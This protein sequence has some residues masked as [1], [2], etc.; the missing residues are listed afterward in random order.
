MSDDAALDALRELAEA[1]FPR[2]YEPD[3]RLLTLT[4]GVG[5]VLPT[6]AVPQ[7]HAARTRFVAALP[8]D[9]QLHILAEVGETGAFANASLGAGWRITA[10]QL[11]AA[12][13]GSA[14]SRV[15]GE[16][17][18]T[19]EAGPLLAATEEVLGEFRRLIAGDEVAAITLTA[20]EGFALPEG[21]SVGLPWGVLRPAGPIEQ[22]VQPFGE[23]AP[24]V[25]LV[26]RSPLRMWIGEPDELLETF[27]R[28]T[29]AAL[30]LAGQHIALAF[31]LAIEGEDFAV[32]DS[33]WQ[34]HLLPGQLGW[35]FSGRLIQNRLFPR[36]AGRPLDDAQIDSL[37]EWAQRVEQHY[38]SSI[39]VAVRRTLSAIR[40]RVDAEDA[41]IDAVIAWENLF[42][43]GG[44]TEVVFRVTSALAVLLESE[45]AKRAEL[46]R[47][48]EKVYAL[49]STV[50]H[51]GEPKPKDNL[52]ERKELAIRTGVDAL[53]ALLRDRP[54]LIKDRERGIRLILGSAGS[55]RRGEEAELASG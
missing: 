41:V 31:L 26:S 47:Q 14:A 11:P 24:T 4:R 23:A 36:A 38:D 34:T 18:P 10:E 32:A 21:A 5:G 49:R 13:V 33:V 30:Q 15:I 29:G 55:K 1:S 42:G 50:V 16:A 44:Q 22:Q 53:R 28:K 6:L 9:P 7:D 52:Q 39:E 45:A 27:D 8:D 17:K 25:V 3:P 43:H 12:L 40:E 51:G 2:V 48:L 35:G 19:D 20:L 37:K 46:R 54:D